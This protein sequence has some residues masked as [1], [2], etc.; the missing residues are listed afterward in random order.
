VG[1]AVTAWR[2]LAAGTEDRVVSEFAERQIERMQIASRNVT[3][4]ADSGVQT[5][6]LPSNMIITQFL[7]QIEE[8]ALQQMSRPEFEAYEK[9]VEAVLSHFGQSLNESERADFD[10]VAAAARDVVEIRREYLEFTERD[11]S[12]QPEEAEQEN[13]DARPDDLYDGPADAETMFVQQTAE[14]AN[15]VVETIRHSRDALARIEAGD[16]AELPAETYREDLN[17]G[18]W[19]AAELAVEY[20]NAHV[21]GAAKDDRQ[22][23]DRIALLEKMREVRDVAYNDGFEGRPIPDIAKGDAK[24]LGYY[25]QG[26]RALEI[27]IAVTDAENGIGSAGWG[28]ADGWWTRQDSKAAWEKFD[29]R[30]RELS[31]FQAKQVLASQRR[32]GAATAAEAANDDRAHERGGDDDR[33]PRPVGDEIDREL[34]GSFSVSERQHAPRAIVRDA[35]EQSTAIARSDPP[36][37]HVP[38]LQELEREIDERHERERDQ[39]ER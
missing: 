31:Q 32:E 17:R 24:L 2:E 22:L 38:R 11:H 29:Q 10:E 5:T 36:Q 23:A 6:H 4:V 14:A 25:E 27:E 8:A 1:E 13:R 15:E 16:H 37:Q 35:P 21:N 33:V 20:E 28:R 19:R 12:V 9:C 26:L 18:L 30:S 7:T 3:R 39:R 34:D